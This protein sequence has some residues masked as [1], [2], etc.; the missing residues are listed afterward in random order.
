MTIRGSFKQPVKPR[1]VHSQNTLEVHLYE[2]T[3][4]LNFSSMF[5]NILMFPLLF[6]KTKQE[7]R[8]ES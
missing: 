4:S 8:G 1:S 7:E 3:A 5:S 2:N 6:Q